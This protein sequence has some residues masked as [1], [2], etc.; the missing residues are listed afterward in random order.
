M[1]AASA[2]GEQLLMF[3][4]V[5]QRNQDVFKMLKTLHVVIDHKRKV[6]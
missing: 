3:V 2:A 6:G 4:L 5:N 1:V